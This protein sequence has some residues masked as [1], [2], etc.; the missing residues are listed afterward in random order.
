MFDLDVSIHTDVYKNNQRDIYYWWKYSRSG[1]IIDYVFRKCELL[2]FSFF[3][4]TGYSGGTHT[5]FN[6][7]SLYDL[8]YITALQHIRVYDITSS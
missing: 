5:Q 1:D 4:G 7:C 6:E 3:P 2:T 8:L